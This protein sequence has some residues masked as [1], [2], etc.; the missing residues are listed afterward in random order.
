MKRGWIA[1]LMIALVLLA[2][3]VELMW[4]DASTGLCLNMLSEADE[5][6]ATNDIEGAVSIAER[7]D[8]R[9]S[10][11][12]G[13]YDLL[14]YHGEVLSI[15]K[16]LGAMRRYAQA[17]ETAEFLAASAAVRRELLSVRNTRLPSL[18]NVF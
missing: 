2:G 16:G 4:I 11:Q 12:A 7:L 1:L 9:F 17:G 3:A 18:G 8:H 14:L 10:E 6:M 13:V 15:S 5:R